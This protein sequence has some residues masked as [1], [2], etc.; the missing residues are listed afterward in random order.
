MTLER[1][2]ACG[3]DAHERRIPLSRS[4]LVDDYCHDCD[5]TGGPCEG[6]GLEGFDLVADDVD[7]AAGR[8]LREWVELRRAGATESELRALAGDR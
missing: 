8:D 2:P 5:L 4:T 3:H 7:V 1:C 6:E